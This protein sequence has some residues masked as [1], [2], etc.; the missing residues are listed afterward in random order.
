VDISTVAGATSAFSI[1]GG[2]GSGRQMRANLGAVQR[3]FTNTIANLQTTSGTD[4][5]A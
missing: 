2:S 1:V 5:I 4:R 3:P